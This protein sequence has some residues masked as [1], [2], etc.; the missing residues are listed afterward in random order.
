MT[1]ARTTAIAESVDV[2]YGIVVAVDCVSPSFVLIS[3]L[4]FAVKPVI[5]AFSFSTLVF[6]LLF[7]VSFD[8]D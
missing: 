1:A 6:N 3:P 8:I 2:G 4:L 7:N 5:V